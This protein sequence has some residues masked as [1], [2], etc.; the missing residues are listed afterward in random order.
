MLRKIHSRFLKQDDI[1]NKKSWYQGDNG[2][3]F[4]WTSR[5]S[6]EIV[7][8]QFTHRH[9]DTL[10]NV[11]VE[12]TEGK[13]LTS[14]VVQDTGS[15]VF[16]ASSTLR[17]DRKLNVK[18]VRDVLDYFRVAKEKLPDDVRALV[19]SRIEAALDELGAL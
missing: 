16:A 11:F 9:P 6:S 5:E 19:T 15:K 14:G 12:W 13:F 2:D 7:R 1:K 4:V 18:I 3:L 10:E 8:F 17:H